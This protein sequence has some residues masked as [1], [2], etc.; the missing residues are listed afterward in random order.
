M[1][2]VSGSGKSSLAF[3]TVY[4]E[5][6]R[7]YVESL[8]SYAR[9]FLGVMDK[10]EV[11]YIEGL[12]PAISIDQKSASHNP[13]STVG[14]VTE[15]YDYLRLL[16]ARAGHP[17]SPK[18]GK[19]LKSQ[20][21]QEIVDSIL[22]LTNKYDSE[23]LKIILLAPVVKSRKGTYEELF[24][25]YLKQGFTRARVDGELFS[26]EEDISLD[27]Y[28]IH[29][30]ELVIDRLILKPDSVDNKDFKKRLIDSVELALNNGDGEL[31]VYLPDQEKEEFYSENLVDPETGESFPQIEPHSFSFNSPHGACEKC[32]GLGN[33]K[34]IKP[35]LFYN[36]KL[37]ITEGGIFPWSKIA[38]N[39]ESWNMRIL[40]AVARDE[41]F[42]LRKPIIDLDKKHLDLV[43]YGSGRKKYKF[44]YIRQRDGEEGTY[45][46]A[47]EGIIPNLLRRYEETKSDYIRNDIE[48]YMIDR[49]CD[50]C[51]GKRLNKI[52][53]AV[54][55]HNQNIYDI[56]EIPI[57]EFLDWVKDLTLSQGDDKLTSMELKIADRIIK[58]IHTRAK[59]LMAVGLD[60][61]TLN[62]TAKT[63]SGGEAQR[64][65]LASQIGTGLSGVIYVLDEPS[66]G[67]HQSDNQKLLNSLKEL[68]DIDNSVIVVEHDEETMLQSD[69]IIDIGPKAG[70]NGGKVVAEGTPKDFVENSNSLTA[71]YLRD[72]LKIKKDKILQKVQKIV[73]DYELKSK[74]KIESQKYIKVEG[75]SHN[76]LK[77]IDVEFPLNKFICVTGVSGSGKSSLVNETLYPKIANVLNRSRRTIGEHESIKGIEHIDKIIDIDQSPIGRTPRSNPATYSGVFT[78]IR[79]LFASTRESKARGYKPGRF[80]FNVKGG[81]CENCSGDGVIKIEMQFLPDVYAKCEVCDG[82]RYNRE[83]LQIDYK[84][85]NIADILDMRVDEALKFF[86]NVPS[87]HSK[88]KTLNQVGLGYIKLGQSAPTL[89]GG[90]AQRVKLAS[91]LSKRSTGK[92]LYILDEPTTGLHFYD[93]EK[94]LIVL[95]SL[96]AKGNTVIVIEHNMD[97]IK[98]ADWIIDLGPKG[99]QDGGE[100]IATGT[101]Q[102]LTKVK[103]SLTGEWL[104]K[105][106]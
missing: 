87:I 32:N 31:Y 94:L 2:G 68:R 63:L 106:L 45:N 5:G 30:I 10:P 77:K 67:L 59:F 104:K 57:K 58:E 97:L 24:T 91:E 36:P 19:R 61:L 92:S 95:H 70:E 84:G 105:Y 8:S 54:T 49:V 46:R 102:E 48:Q 82:K 64:I 28:K 103:K 78:P 75:A 101:P 9:Q 26:L 81:R 86:D 20:T 6:Q 90:E 33:I 44:K 66:I 1:T 72:E 39:P 22:K 100:V 38:T 83:T 99:G 14:T 27:R 73:P 43:L 41:N 80:S 25:R 71:K 34:D 62:R 3:D 52:S 11:D 7:R 53:L 79:D 51:E 37:S 85:K 60:Y 65:R 76:N 35:E 74:K 93:I 96:V 69:W 47:F 15:I 21:P 29:N 16:F 23:K 50:A 18:T 40:Q 42:D 13:R 12:A 56:C 89:S 55:I 98:T 17:R 88:L 4:A